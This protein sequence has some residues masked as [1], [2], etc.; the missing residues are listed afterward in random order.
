MEIERHIF[1]VHSNICFRI[2]CAVI[3]ERQL[4]PEA[5]RIIVGR[6]YSHPQLA[7]MRT[8]NEWQLPYTPGRLGQAHDRLVRDFDQTLFSLASGPFHA[9]VPQ[10]TIPFVALLVGH[11]ECQGFSYLE[12]GIAAY[13]PIDAIN[14]LYGGY[15]FRGKRVL[16]GYK[17][18]RFRP[19]PFYDLRH[20]SGWYASS[21]EAFA[22]ST[23][24]TVLASVFDPIG[25]DSP[26]LNTS[27]IHC[28]MDGLSLYFP[29]LREAHIEAMAEGI[30]RVAQ[31]HGLS[32]VSIKPP[33]IA[34]GLDEARLL[35]AELVQRCNLDAAPD[36]CSG[37]IDMERS[38]FISQPLCLITVASSLGLYARR[39][40]HEV[41]SCA[42][43]M[44]P[45]I[46]RL[47][48][49]RH[50]AD[51]RSVAIRFEPLP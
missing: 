21:D 13:Q 18:R 11:P 47:M 30:R 23:N 1:Y 7:E 4:P 24:R 8:T 16:E 41:Y 33:P 36:I 10:T 32:R 3:R 26:P 19:R 44:L 40:G 37:P 35:A 31:H 14:G 12:E 34:G 51:I 46:D 42:A 39:F 29:C 6:S 48:G 22:F 17:H 43:L 28:V 27:V 15:W 9:Y 20:A 38:L 25:Q 2:A 50:A 49:P 45:A 5:V